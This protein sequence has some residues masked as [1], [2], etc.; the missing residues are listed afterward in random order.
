M[1][2]THGLHGQIA[3]PEG[4]LL[5]HAGDVSA[6]GE[7][8]QVEE[9]LS[10]FALQPH[11]HKVFIAG[12]HDFL[13][14]RNPALFEELVPAGIHYLNDSGAT[15]AGLRI[16]GSPVTPWF[17]DW[18]F[19]RRRGEEIRRHW[20]MIP[21]G[22]DILLTHG[23]VYGIRDLTFDGRLVGCEELNARVWH[24]KPKLHVFGHIHEGHG[25]T[26]VNGT[27]FVNAAALDVHYKPVNAPIVV[28]W[29][30]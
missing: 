18:A 13:A 2:D 3:V 28:E 22:I 15:V 8:R 26:E 23:P 20:S 9:F 29:E 17:Y 16:W 10:W 24:V 12:N 14:E 27:T 21:P 19:N 7:L 5:L 1:S 6:M 11:P 4:D 25:I 30:G